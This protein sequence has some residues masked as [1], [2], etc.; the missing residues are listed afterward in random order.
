M[1][2]GNAAEAGIGNHWLSFG[3][4]PAIRVESK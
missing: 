3:F 4:P 2:R 1:H